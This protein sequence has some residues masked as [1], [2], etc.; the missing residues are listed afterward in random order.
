MPTAR[1][2]RRWW[3]SSSSSSSWGVIAAMTMTMTMT[4][5][6]GADAVTWPAG[7][8][9]LDASMG[10]ATAATTV[11]HDAYAYYG[12][13]VLSAGSDVDIVVDVR[14]GDAGT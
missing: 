12:F 1:R 10:T 5:T 7:A 9:T 8:T 6:M 2:R 4:M 13:T 14:D 11:T 3:W